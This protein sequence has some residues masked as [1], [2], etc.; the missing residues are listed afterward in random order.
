MKLLKEFA[1]H[2]KATDR[3]IENKNKIYE[4]ALNFFEISE[5]DVIDLNTNEII[6]KMKA[7]IRDVKLEKIL[8]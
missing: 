1:Y 4:E 3:A 6:S 8:S 7:K 2:T 5:K